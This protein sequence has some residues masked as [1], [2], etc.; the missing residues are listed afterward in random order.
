VNGIALSIDGTCRKD[1]RSGCEERGKWYV[2]GRLVASSTDQEPDNVTFID[3]EHHG[4]GCSSGHLSQG[5][6]SIVFPM[7]SIVSKTTMRGRQVIVSTIP[8]LLLLQLF[9]TGPVLSTTI[10]KCLEVQYGATLHGY[11]MNL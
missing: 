5:G 2:D 3:A 1:P 6:H 9:Y 8:S 7:S 11:S 10:K 4:L